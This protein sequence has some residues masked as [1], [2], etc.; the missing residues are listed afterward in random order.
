MT[1]KW[2][3]NIFVMAMKNEASSELADIIADAQA[4]VLLFQSAVSQ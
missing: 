4:P 3:T 1:A 2:S